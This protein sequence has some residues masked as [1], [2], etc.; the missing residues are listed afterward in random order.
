MV[1]APVLMLASVLSVQFGQAF[2]KGLFGSV[3]PWGVVALR[4][5]FAALVLLAVSRPALPRDPRRIAL[6][7]GFGAAIAGMN[8]IYPAL[9]YL[10]LGV[11]SGIQLLGPFTVA[12]IT[13]RRLADVVFACLAGFGVWLVHRPGGDALAVTGVL[14]AV[15]SAVAMGGYLLLSRRAGE[16]SADGSLLALAVGFAAVLTVPAGLAENGAALFRPHVLLA[17]AGVA[18]LSAVLPYSLELAALRRVPPRVV[19]VLACL[20][21]AVAGIAGAVVLAETLPV[22][23][24]LG[25]G[26]IVT[27]AGLASTR[28]RARDPGDTIGSSGSPEDARPG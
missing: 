10:P 22:P 26:C 5:G 6:V 21:P 12:I 9:E 17:G 28:G 7:A 18:I 19:A 13:S 27:A 8:A 24:W 23:A 2:G 11:A 1:P 25:I 14:F 15:V 3:G 20:E 4:L 16:R